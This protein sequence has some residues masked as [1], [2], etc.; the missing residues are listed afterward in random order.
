[1][2]NW[3]KRIEPDSSEPSDD[4]AVSRSTSF[5]DL[6]AAGLKPAHGV[7]GFIK[8]SID[9]SAALFLITILLPVLVFL[10]L[11]ITRDGGHA[12]FGHVRIGRGGRPFRCWKFRSM[13]KDA[14]AVLEQLLCSSP[15][16]RAE[17]ARDFKLKNDIR[18]TPMGK[19]LR[20]TSLDELPQLWNVLRGDMSLVGPRPIVEQELA[21]YGPDASYYLMVK[22]GITGLWQVSG[23][24]DVDYATRISLDVSYAKNCSLLLDIS[25]LLRTFKVVWERDGAY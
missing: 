23:R 7:T 14:D 16:A 17:W 19:I 21:R 13:V 15:Q 3:E 4:V 10:A 22:P 20:S 18:I 11:L 2:H 8:R 12:V 6:A 1:M 25:I 24:N 5:D 9:I